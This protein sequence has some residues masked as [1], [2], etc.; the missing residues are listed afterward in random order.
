MNFDFASKEEVALMQHNMKFYPDKFTNTE[1]EEDM[2]NVSNQHN[3]TMN[4]VY[5]DTF[6][7]DNIGTIIPPNYS[8]VIK[9]IIASTDNWKE[10]IG[11]GT[12]FYSELKNGNFR[13]AKNKLQRLSFY[14]NQ[15]DRQD[16]FNSW[17]NFWNVSYNK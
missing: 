2:I 6:S 17:L 9:D 3:A 14:F 8:F 15:I 1:N 16:Q 12:A 7:I 5:N 4:D 10:L 13:F 11:E